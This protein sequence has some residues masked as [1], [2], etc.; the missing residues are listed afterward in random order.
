MFA[1]SPAT[2]LPQQWRTFQML[3]ISH[4]AYVKSYFSHFVCPNPKKFS[5]V[6]RSGFKPR[7]RLYIFTIHTTNKTKT[8]YFWKKIGKAVQ[9]FF[10]TPL[11]K[12][13]NQ[14]AAV[15]IP[16]IGLILLYFIPKNTA[17]YNFFQISK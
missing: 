11:R 13:K 15:S 10:K 8:T 2:V 9:I 4:F 16:S 7:Y 17:K 1:F 12:L 6:T 3:V 14:K 5:K